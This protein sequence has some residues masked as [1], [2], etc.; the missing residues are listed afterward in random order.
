MKFKLVDHKEYLFE[1]LRVPARRIG[2]I[3]AAWETGD[4]KYF[5]KA[6]KN[7]ADALGGMQKL[8]KETQLARESLYTMLS[9]K[10]NPTLSSLEKVLHAFGVRIVFDKVKSSVGRPESTKQKP[11]AVLQLAESH[12]KYRD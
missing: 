6:L 9:D 3:N 7:V 5:L 2:Y 4:F 10:G 8:S 12:T 11:P 1:E